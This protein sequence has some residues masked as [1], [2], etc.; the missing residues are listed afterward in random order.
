MFICNA[1]PKLNGIGRVA[2]S[3]VKIA[4]AT[5]GAHPTPV[6]VVVNVDMNLAREIA[7]ADLF[8][9]RSAYFALLSR[10]TLA[11][12]KRQSDGYGWEGEAKKDLFD[13]FTFSESGL[14][15]HFP[16]Y[17]AGSYADGGI[18]VTLSLDQLRSVAREGGS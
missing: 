3:Y 11:D 8:T 12:L 5:G 4:A 1:A 2:S 6:R 10:L 16:P 15:I 7:L 9:V 13:N 14:V 17:L 18:E